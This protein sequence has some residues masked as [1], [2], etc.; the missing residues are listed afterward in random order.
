VIHI[1][2]PVGYWGE[3]VCFVGVAERKLLQDH[4]SKGDAAKIVKTIGLREGVEGC[5]AWPERR[6][7][8]ANSPIL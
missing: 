6:I 2:L 5:S 4:E 1:P 7:A 3:V 8:D